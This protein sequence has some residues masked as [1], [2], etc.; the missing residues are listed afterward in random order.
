MIRSRT[1]QLILQSCYVA[2]GVVGIFGSLGLYDAEFDPDFFVYFT[3]LSN[4]LCIG[5]MLCELVATARRRG[6]G[7][8]RL[9]PALKFVSVIAI[10]L[11]FFVFNL[12][13]AGQ[14]DRDPAKN[15]E[16]TSITFHVVLPL[17]FTFDWLLCYEHRRVKWTYPLAA[18]IFPLCYVGFVYVRAWLYGFDADVPLL[19]PYFFLDASEIGV[20]GVLR[21]IGVLLV[22]F[23]IFGYLMMAVDRVLPRGSRGT[24]ASTDALTATDGAVISDR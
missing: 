24:D 18:T 20:G 8:V 17:M 13:L 19:Y 23:I 5:F 2:L 4:Y 22:A 7:P 15:F 1:A 12:L 3:N 11:T 21:W 14:P 10:L 6:D 9:H 16:V